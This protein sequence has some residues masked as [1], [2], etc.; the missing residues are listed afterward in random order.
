MAKGLRYHEMQK[1][2]EGSAPSH[3]PTPVPYTSSVVTQNKQHGSSSSGSLPAMLLPHS[4]TTALPRR[5]ED[6]K[7]AARVIL[8]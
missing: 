2:L 7:G 3:K 6:Q 1:D 8:T 4:Q 5:Y